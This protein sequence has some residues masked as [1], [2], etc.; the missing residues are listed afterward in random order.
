MDDIRVPLTVYSFLPHSV[1]ATPNDG[2]LYIG[3]AGGLKVGYI[4]N[5]KA[6]VPV[7]DHFH[8]YSPQTIRAID[9]DPDWN[10]K[11]QFAILTSN[12]LVHVWD[13]NKKEPV[14][15]HRALEQSTSSPQSST[16]AMCYLKTKKIIAVDSERCVIYCASSNTYSMS[17][18]GALLKNNTV[19]LLKACPYDW[20]LVAAGTKN[21]LILISKVSG[22]MTYQGTLNDLLINFPL[23]YRQIYPFYIN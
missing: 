19:T 22:K 15:G 3:G 8:G 9:C 12:N 13:L 1:V 10:E 17:T 7:I 2:V 11:Q 4:G 18:G 16:G 20:N 21:G 6:D 23:T 5:V 14:Y